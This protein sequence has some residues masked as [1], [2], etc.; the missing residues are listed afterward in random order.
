[1]ARPA[2][3]TLGGRR[4]RAAEPGHPD[5]RADRERAQGRR[6]GSAADGR[7]RI[8]AKT[9]RG[10]NA[11]GSDPVRGAGAGVDPSRIADGTRRAAQII[12]ARQTLQ[13][14]D[15]GHPLCRRGAAQRGS[16]RAALDRR[17]YGQDA[18]QQHFSEARHPRPRRTGALCASRWIGGRAARQA[19]ASLR[20]TAAT[21]RARAYLPIPATRF[22]FNSQGRK[23]VSGRI[24]A[25]ISPA[26][27]RA[28]RSTTCKAAELPAAPVC[29][30]L[31]I[32]WISVIRHTQAQLGRQPNEGSYSIVS[33]PK[34]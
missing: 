33:G 31:L 29:G 15:R 30:E 32:L 7:A 17:E 28:W 4:Y 6:D 3:G 14:R 13:P 10:G 5:R 2:N 26:R 27:A 16:G 12:L 11:D 22:S 24:A 18:S 20:V 1:P 21:L 8:R 34:P 9:L 19:L 23:A 25:P